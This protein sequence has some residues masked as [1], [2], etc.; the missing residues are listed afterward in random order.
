MG[1]WSTQAADIISENNISQNVTIH[2]IT[3]NESRWSF[4]QNK[5]QLS[6]TSCFA[7]TNN[8]NQG[9]LKHVGLYLPNLVFSH[10]HAYVVMSRI[11]SREGLVI[12]NADVEADS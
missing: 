7:I 8:K 11:I 2:I 12:L 5:R 3:P 6:V 4:K 1:K 9:S 10:V